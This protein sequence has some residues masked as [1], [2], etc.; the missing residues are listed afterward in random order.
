MTGSGQITRQ[1]GEFQQIARAHRAGAS[2]EHEAHH[3]PRAY[4]Q[5][6]DPVPLGHISLHHLNGFTLVGTELTGDGGACLVHGMPSELS[7]F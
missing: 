7:S 3:A 2:V 1:R 6:T 4:S 5:S